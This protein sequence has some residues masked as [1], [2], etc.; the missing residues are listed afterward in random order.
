M[1]H[2]LLSL[3]LVSGL[4]MPVLAQTAASPVIKP[5]APQSQ[6]DAV[7][8]K[9]K[10]IEQEFNKKQ[11]EAANSTAVA[12]LKFDNSFPDLGKISD[13]A[14]VPYKFGFT[15]SSDKTITISN[16]TP[17]CGCTATN[18]QTMKK[19][20]NPGEKG[21]LEITFDPA[22]KRGIETKHVTVDTDFAAAPRVEL[23]FK[24][25]ILPRVTIEPP[26]ITMVEVR[27]GTPAEQIVY[28]T[29]REKNFDVTGFTMADPD[30]IVTRLE[31]QEMKDGDDT[32]TRIGFKVVASDKIMPTGFNRKSAIL[33]LTTND[34]K[35]SLLPVGVS[36]NVVG[37]ARVLPDRIPLR[38]TSV[39]EAWS[40]EV[41]IEHRD[42][43]SFEVT[44]IESDAPQDMRVIFDVE[45]NPKGMPVGYKIKV[46]GVA[47][48]TV[49]AVNC[50][51][52]VRTNVPDQEAIMIPIMGMLLAP[53]AVMPQGASAQPV[54]LNRVN[55]QV[56]PAAPASAAAK[57]AGK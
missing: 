26:A 56:N 39:G 19:T 53:S 50:N 52:I 36:I 55:P 51:I 7:K 10:L 49:G 46:A 23:N 45:P 5:S 29:G 28:V 6:E 48:G 43:Q 57:P 47:P 41:R 33:N 16:V 38:M 1:R 12:G 44:G 27:K 14:R 34:P 32:L 31:K 9:Q 8:A 11:A 42:G 17:G 30:F 18:F 24:V 25:E 35:K 22:S 15:N 20:Y 2:T 54:N 4:A 37:A 21:E 3:V 40:R 13:D